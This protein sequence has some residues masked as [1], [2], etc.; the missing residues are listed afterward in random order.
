MHQGSFCIQAASGPRQFQTDRHLIIH[1]PCT[2]TDQV[3]VT[4]SSDFPITSASS[5]GAD[6]TDDGNDT[7]K[8]E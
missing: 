1:L 6:I 8:R 7:V 2:R 3:G 5:E 4:I